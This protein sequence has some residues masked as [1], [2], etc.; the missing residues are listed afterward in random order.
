MNQTLDGR[1]VLVTGA[2][3]GLGAQFVQQALDR[4]ARKVYAATRSAGRWTDPRIQHLP[5]DLTGTDDAARA[6]ATASDVDLLVNNA[7]IAPA[8]DSISGPEDELRRT[9]ETN[10]FGTLRVANAFAPVLAANGGGTL[11]NILSAAAW[12]NIPTGYA[13]SK[14]AMW[15]ATNGLRPQL[16]AQ[17][18][19]VIGLLVGMVDT[20]MTERWDVPKVTAESVVA[21]AYDGVAEGAIEV[22]ADEPTRDLRSRMGTR[23][24]ELYPWLDEQ[25]GAFVP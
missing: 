18:T 17:G 7:G 24:E 19:H 22:L 4:G 6:A 21:Q 8:G 11:L 20:P 2:N 12:S 23:A 14:A 25:L 16:R 13:A 10:F 9:F 3:G 1:T 5:L 15:S